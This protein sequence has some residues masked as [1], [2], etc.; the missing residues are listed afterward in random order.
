MK[1]TVVKSDVGT[2]LSNLRKRGRRTW[3]RRQ[4]QFT[5][6]W[7]ECSAV[8]GTEES[9]GNFI[10]ESASRLGFAERLKMGKLF[11]CRGGE[12]RIH[13]NRIGKEYFSCLEK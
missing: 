8:G 4:N 6:T 7:K 11:N 13:G 9:K 1:I 10:G 12:K 5:R 2:R 3:K